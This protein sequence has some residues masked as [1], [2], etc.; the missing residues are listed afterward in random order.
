MLS[1]VEGLS[2]AGDRAKQNDDAFGFAEGCAW[3]IDGATD[4][5]DQ[6]FSGAA[7]DA[8][9]LAHFANAHL[10]GAAGDDDLRARIAATSAAAAKAFAALT[11]GAPY[12]RWQSPIASLLMIGAASHGVFWF[13][14]GDCRVFT[15]DADCE[16]GEA[17]APPGAVDAETTLAAAQTDRDKPLLQRAATIEKLRHMRADLNREGAHRTFGL[18]PE[19]AAH[20][21]F[22]TLSLQPPAHVLLMTDGFA[23]LVDRYR[24]Y[25]VAGL[26]RAALATGLHE[27]GRELRAIEAEDAGGTRHPRFKKSDDATALLMRLT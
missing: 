2:L 24:A 12:E 10:H 20:A 3:V 16:T 1:F 15:L 9:W 19:C 4:L 18:D 23:A 6:P 25:D 22:W 8:A 11:D 5:H 21:R 17:G 26:V 14:L 7:S 13:D 27:L